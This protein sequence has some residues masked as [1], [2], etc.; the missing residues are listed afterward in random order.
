[1]MNFF[2][3]RYFMLKNASNSFRARFVLAFILFIG[4][5]GIQVPKP[6]LAATLIVT[7]T[8]DIDSGSL[9]QAIFDA[10]SGDTIT[11]NASLAG[12]TITL[13]STL[14]V[15]KNLTIDGSSLIT[16]INISGNNNVVVFSVNPG[17]MLTIKNL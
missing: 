10:V 15:D 3:G 12:Q 11:F 8:N 4:M 9:R 6:V 16:K 2:P 5:L 17:I 14:V 7:S 13:G 1:M